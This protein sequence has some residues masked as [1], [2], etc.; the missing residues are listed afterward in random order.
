MQSP[1]ETLIARLEREGERLAAWLRA[2]ES[3]EIR[4]KPAP[5]RWS[6]LEVIGH[7][8]DE[9]RDDFRAR[10]GL[11]LQ[12][13]APW[14]PI[15]PEGAVVAG[16]WQERNPALAIDEFEEERQRSLAWL[17]GLKNP[18]WQ[19]TYEHI[20]VGTISAL[21]LLASWV[22]HDLLHT[23]QLARLQVE[24]FQALNERLSTRYADPS[25]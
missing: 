1:A 5:E 7:L 14:P 2:Q 8:C 17:R 21:D 6:M 18:D 4:W 19:L 12:G 3:G 22:A 11:T 13:V 10:V 20:E 9:E 16:G 23:R 24:A 15:D 25:A